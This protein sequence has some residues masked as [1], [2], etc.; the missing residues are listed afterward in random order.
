MLHAQQNNRTPAFTLTKTLVLGF[1]ISSA[2]ALAQQSSPPEEITVVGVLPSGTA[3]DARLVP[4]PVQQAGAA[5]L[6]KAFASSA[7]PAC[8]TG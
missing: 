8:W 1:A 4:Y 6:A 2:S 7:A 3:L 5:E